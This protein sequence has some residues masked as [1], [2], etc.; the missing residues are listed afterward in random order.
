MKQACLLSTL[1]TVCPTSVTPWAT[2]TLPA[3][4]GETMNKLNRLSLLSH[5]LAKK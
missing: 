2:T 1:N 3:I 5:L 4:K